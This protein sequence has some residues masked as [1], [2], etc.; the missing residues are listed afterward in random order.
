M[1]PITDVMRE[2]RKG[3]IVDKASEMLAD[4]VHAV[5]ETGK[6]GSITI[7]LTVKPEKGGGSQKTISAK[8]TATKPE[9]DLPEAIFF[10]DTEGTLHR[11]DPD[12]R[13]MFAE[14]ERGDRLDQRP[15]AR[16]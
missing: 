5:D 7:K 2:I 3:R 15:A 4:V 10:S 8:L 1:K 9:E 13:E 14:A 12:Q 6:A 16:G 11:N